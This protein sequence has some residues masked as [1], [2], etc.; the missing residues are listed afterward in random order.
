MR[1]LII[2]H[3]AHYRTPHGLTSWGPT[4]RELDYLAVLFDHVVHVA[5]VYDDPS[6]ASA[7]PYTTSGI[8]VRGVQPAGG[9]T[10]GSKAGILL[11]YPQYARVIREEMAQADVVHVRC[12]A[13][14]SLLTLGLLRV[15]KEP[16]YRWVK[17]AGNWQPE[18]HEPW[19]YGLQR[20]WL[21]DNV[22]HG[23]VT[24]NGRWPRQ[25]EHVYSFL[26]PCL[27]DVELAEGAVAA[28]DKWLGSRIELLFVGALNE[29]KGVSR[30][31]AV[32]QQLQA[33][34]VPYRLRLA[35]DGPDRPRYEAWVSEQGLTSVE[36]LGWVQRSRMPDYYSL[37][38]FILLPS[39]SEGWPKV[40][41]EAMAYGV[42]PIAGAVSSIPQILGST[43]AGV[44][45]A[46]GD[47]R[48]MSDAIQHYAQDP[49][50]WTAASR[51]GTVAAQQFS[52]RTYQQAVTDLFARAWGLRLKQP[53][54][55]DRTPTA[56]FSVLQSSNGHGQHRV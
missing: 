28:G 35:G 8:R 39:Q 53:P 48:G 34:G 19:S 32:A 50:S 33:A 21:Q 36:F 13:N 27:T 41:S 56:G 11:A 45:F 17:Y 47:I 43:G 54:A 29:W 40:L 14:I 7:L 24:I 5:P 6:P 2:S 1:L 15:V 49:A 3:T 42:V 10:L 44:T 31:L 9:R 23:V 52:Y 12:P 51:A 37:A 55:D 16:A 25:P 20:R 46:P 22:H 38:H 4:A 26:N 18:G 30:V